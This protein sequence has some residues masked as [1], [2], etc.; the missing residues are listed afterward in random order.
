MYSTIKKLFMAILFALAITQIQAKIILIPYDGLMIAVKVKD[1]AGVPIAD[2]GVDKSTRV[3]QPVT[4]NGSGTD[5]DGTIVSY[6]WKKGNVVLASSASFDYIPT[7]EGKETLTLTVMDNDGLKDSDSMVVTTVLNNPPVA[8]AGTDKSTQVNQAVTITGTAHDDDGSITSVKWVKNGQ[9]L[10]TTLQFDYTPTVIGT[11][12]LTLLVK[13]NDGIS[14][15]DTMKVTVTA[16]SNIPPVITILGDNPVVILKDSTYNDAG[17]TA[18]DNIDGNIPVHV[19]NFVNTNIIGIQSVIYTATNSSENVAQERRVVNVV[20]NINLVAKSDH[21]SISNL[22]DPVT[23]DVLDNDT[24]NTGNPV[25]VSVNSSSCGCSSP[26]V[27]LAST[28][29]VWK[30]TSDNKVTFTPN[31]NS[32][33][34]IARTTYRV[35]DTNGNIS[36]AVVE[37]EYPKVFFAEADSKKET[38]IQTSLIDILK[39]DVVPDK[40]L[41]NI[42]LQNSGLDNDG[43]WSLVD[44]K[45]LFNPSQSFGG[46]HVVSSYT[47]NDDFGHYSYTTININYPKIFV[48]KNDEAQFNV[49][50]EKSISILSNDILISPSDTT[51]KFIY[52]GNDGQEIGTFVETMD[53]NWSILEQKAVFTPNANYGGGQ[54]WMQYQISDTNGYVSTA[55]IQIKY[56][57]EFYAEGDYEYPA[58]LAPQT[59][60]VLENDTYP[61]GATIIVTLDN[62]YGPQGGVWSVNGQDVI[63]T[64]D[65]SFGGGQVYTGYIITDEN[66]RSSFAYI[67]IDYPKEF[68]AEYDNVDSIDLIA[69]TVH[70]LEND[71]Y[72]TGAT[73]TVTLDNNYGPQSGV[74]SV[75]GQNVIFTPDANFGG[76]QVG[77]QY[78]ITDQNGRSSSAYISINYPKEFYAEYDNV[79]PSDL[80]PQTVNVLENDTY[81]S[82]ATITVT[83]DNNY[84]PQSGVWSVNGQ[85]VI[86]TPDAN[87]GGGQVYTQYTITD[88]N[89]RSASA[90]IN[91]DYHKEFYAEQD[92]VNP[93]DLS[94][95]T[96]HVLENDTYPSG[97]QITVSIDGN[98]GPQGGTWSVSGQDVV[99]TPD[100]GFGGGQVYTQY[101]I[102]DQN[103]RSASAGINIDYHKEFYAKQDEVNPSDLSAQ[104][105]HVL[106]NDTYP[107]GA[108]ITVSIDGNYGPQ[109]GTWSVS[110]QDVVFTPDNGFGGGQ[111]Y[112]QYTITDQNGRSA[113]AGINID[114]HKE[115]YAEQDEVNPSDLSAQTVH[116]LENDTYPSGAQINVSIDGNYGPQGGT[117]SVSGQ[118]VVFT[119][120]N[121]F[122]GGQVYTQYTI[123]DAN[124]RSASAGININYP[125]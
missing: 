42:T 37:I 6:E 80:S 90:G 5:T 51:I 14:D 97:A 66:G 35:R 52:Y 113:S 19:S 59:V 83:L 78:T 41:V 107:S 87:F 77:N 15:T 82:G 101:T 110:G 95:Q 55:H 4:I 102:T 109:G 10:A 114:Y 13:D 44:R 103:G 39:N 54:I 84:G 117:W 108:Q 116:V 25:T 27:P 43:N 26:G 112:T 81:P 9:T 46:G 120:D 20:N 69:Q 98:Y 71:T 29:G 86:F 28:Y 96:V 33:G 3:G 74:W 45:V 67:S 24:L 49:I 123:T 11:D 79:N 119:P 36:E 73:I 124:G 22:N 94:A 32:S 125:I 2:A 63:F 50:E 30:V 58:S 48:A 104:T 88:Q 23:V 85:N 64:P 75:N 89:G 40:S 38:S 93:S 68:Y 111:V 47:I 100:N 31:T 99:F 60:H 92:E 122:G 8:D 56:K 61:S 62:N 105:V 17:A 57:K 12:T 70:V 34:G 106:E 7:Q 16:A 18:Q 21:E 118:D 72:P 91:I 115:F 76:G 53:G 121:G 65:N 1:P